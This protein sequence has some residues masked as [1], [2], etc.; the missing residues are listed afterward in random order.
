ML[1]AGTRFPDGAVAATRRSVLL[2]GL[3]LLATSA[4]PLLATSSMLSPL[5]A[6]EHTA[7]D[8]FIDDIQERTFRFFWET[9]NPRNG[10]AR[11]RFPSS[12][13]SS[14]AAV[15]FALTAYPIGVE[16]GYITRQAA[17]RLRIIA[18][19]VFSR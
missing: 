11:D 12:S 17:R 6:F 13:P 3:G 14:I 15:G 2:G 4:L 16:R 7:F 9:S 8:P 10:L 18:E 1:D 19:N 5:C